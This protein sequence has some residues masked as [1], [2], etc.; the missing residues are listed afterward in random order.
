MNK[1]P[2]RACREP[3]CVGYAVHG[4]P[5]CGQHAAV[6][7][8]FPLLYKLPQIQKHVIELSYLDGHRWTYIS[9]KLHYDESSVRRLETAAVTTLAD[10]FDFETEE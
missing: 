8:R 5:Y 3:G 9:L 2:N 6:H 7:A 1:K 4:S 10:N